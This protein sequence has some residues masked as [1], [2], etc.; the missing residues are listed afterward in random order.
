MDGWPLAGVSQNSCGDQTLD[1]KGRSELL[2]K[3]TIE[4]RKWTL[5]RKRATEAPTKLRFCSRPN[6]PAKWD[7]RESESYALYIG[8]PDTF[9]Q[10]ICKFQRCSFAKFARSTNT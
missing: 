1:C 4:L 5:T 3:A 7:S 10:A 2:W 8:T 9:E 6:S